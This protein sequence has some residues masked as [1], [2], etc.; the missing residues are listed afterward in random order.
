MKTLLKFALAGA[1]AAIAI[2]L[3]R[4]W[5]KDEGSVLGEPESTGGPV[6]DWEPDA[7]NPLRGENLSVEPTVTH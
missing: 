7:A 1:L 3:A 6:G 4:Q 5:S 2:E